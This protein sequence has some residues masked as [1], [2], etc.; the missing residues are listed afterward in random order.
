MEM[1]RIDF[2]KKYK[3]YLDHYMKFCLSGLP[4][5]Q[6][7]V[8]QM[9]IQ[10]GSWT[11]HEIIHIGLGDC[12]FK[13]E[14]DIMRWVLL[15]IG[16]EVQHVWSTTQ[17]AWE[18]GLSGG[19]HAVCEVLSSEIETRRRL[20][21]KEED[22]DRFL[23]DIKKNGYNLSK[24]AIQNFVHF[25]VNS[26]EDG[27]IERIRCVKRPNFRNYVVFCRGYDWENEPVPEEFQNDLESAR[28]YL[29]VILN[30]VLIL[31][32]M[33]IYQKGFMDVCGKD[34]H[35]HMA[36]Q[37]V[38]PHIRAGISSSSCRN[39]MAEAIE[40]C[41]ILAVEIAEACKKTPE[42]EWLE[43]LLKGLISD[44]TKKQAFSADSRTEEIG[45][46][47]R[48]DISI[49][50]FGISDLVTD[51]ET[52]KPE[53]SKKEN[54][55]ACELE[56]STKISESIEAAEID[57]EQEIVSAMESGNVDKKSLPSATMANQMPE[58]IDFS[59]VNEAYD[60]AD[61]MHFEEQV[62]DYQ[63]TDLLPRDLLAE[64]NNMKRKVEKILKNRSIPSVRGMKNGRLDKSFIYKIPMGQMDVFSK[65][66]KPS[67]CEAVLFVLKDDSGSM[68]DGGRQQAVL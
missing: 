8:L 26:L 44:G 40:I 35:I 7:P 10:D 46:E 11:N 57:S 48:E 24:T 4:R 21:R 28:T 65:K 45:S 51:N 1:E 31:A 66:G 63:P 22:Y 13:E 62:R 67:E 16:H 27:R 12:P 20:F 37:K 18:Y 54:S 52:G 23:Q 36:V 34:K 38:I 53:D 59:D 2:I 43:E 42:E 29:V 6:N 41:R 64:A 33:Q 30:Q 58:D 25:I 68:G 19:Y 3:S 17:K 14:S 39:C 15:R 55:D 5:K 50:L 56:I 49:A 60:Y 61:K 47:Q 9:D 32:T